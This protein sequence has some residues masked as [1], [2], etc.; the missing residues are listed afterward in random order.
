[1]IAIMTIPKPQRMRFFLN[2]FLALS[3]GVSALSSIS[4]SPSPTV[5][6][7]SRSVV[8]PPSSVGITIGPPLLDRPCSTPLGAGRDAAGAEVCTG[9][10]GIGLGPDMGSGRE[11]GLPLEGA[12]D[13]D[14]EVVVPVSGVVGT[15]LGLG[16]LG[17]TGLF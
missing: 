17:A 11:T 4:S 9:L 16:E 6:T 1:M 15:G 12:A 5:F 14:F 8:N 3:S 7:G 10:V 13:L 2:F